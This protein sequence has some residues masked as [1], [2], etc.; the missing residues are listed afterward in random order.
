MLACAHTGFSLAITGHSCN[1][2]DFAVC[3]GCVGKA[4]WQGTNSVMKQ[5][6][7]YRA[8][9]VRTPFLFALAS[10]WDDDLLQHLLPDCYLHVPL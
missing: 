7:R 3:F 6:G 2:K 10:R 1:C 5:K 9:C 8:K 4:L